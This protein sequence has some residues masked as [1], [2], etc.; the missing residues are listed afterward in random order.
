MDTVSRNVI[1]CNRVEFELVFKEKLLWR[2]L[3]PIAFITAINNDKILQLLSLV[4]ID[5]M[6]LKP[7]R[8]DLTSIVFHSATEFE[9]FLCKY[10]N[11]KM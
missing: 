2:L 4:M 6:F 3:T 7:V 11:N 8:I 10:S 9:Q 5:L 1:I